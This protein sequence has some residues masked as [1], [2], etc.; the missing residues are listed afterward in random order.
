MITKDKIKKL[1]GFFN[2]RVDIVMAFI[3]GS[4]AK[5]RTTTDSD[6]DLA[7]YFK[8]DDKKVEVE[9]R[10]KEYPQEGEIYGSCVDILGTD[11]IDLVILNRAPANIAEEAL[12]GI[13]LIV[14]DR[15]LWLEFMLIVTGRAEDFRSFVRDYDKIY[16]RS[17]SLT[18]QDA[19]SLARRLEFLNSELDLI[20]KYEDL[21][22][23][24]YQDNDIK[25]RGVERSIE[26][27]MNA[28]IDISKIILASQKRPAP[29]GYKQIVESAS[30]FLKMPEE[31][32]KHISSWASLH[33]ILAHEYL[34]IR[35]KD[36][37]AFLGN[38]NVVWTFLN[39][40]RNF[41]HN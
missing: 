38:L 27:F 17:Q 29:Q 25:R 8:T 13:P 9:E 35:W 20:K 41:T 6:I 19:Y 5:G 15:R 3:F 23:H 12:S 40:A 4:Y 34:D 28:V 30:L 10:E 37:S 7:V 14:K 22:W 2:S 16:W 36:I 31:E 32:V 1:E 33:N 18:S 21:S 24:E 39:T 11:K 26:N